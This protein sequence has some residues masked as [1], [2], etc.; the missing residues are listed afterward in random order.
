[1]RKFLTILS[2][3]LCTTF[4]LNA[5]FA[6]ETNVY[7]TPPTRLDA[8]ETNTDTI[9]IRASALMG[10]VA[11]SG[12][13]VSVKARDFTDAG[14]NQRELGISIDIAMGGLRVDSVLIDYDELNGLLNG[15]DYL[16]RVDW[17]IT[18]FPAF[19]ASFTTR[20]GFRVLAYGGRRTGAIE[21]SVRTSRTASPALPLSRDQLG[22]LR[23]LVDQAKAK[24]DAIRK[25]K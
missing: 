2:V 25:E 20:G 18:S 23:S 22:Q 6:Q 7:L 17:S 15:I 8:M 19:D 21:Y 11:A 1:M 9:L 10:S 12:G 16:N 3:S 4:L 24:L 14:A 13:T 5:A